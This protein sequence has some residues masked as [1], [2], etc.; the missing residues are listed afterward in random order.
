MRL[1]SV[2]WF[3]SL[4]A[5]IKDPGAFSA[6]SQLPDP[7]AQA[8]DHFWQVALAAARLD[9]DARVRAREAQLETAAAE[10]AERARA[11]A[12]REEILQQAAF[13]AAARAQQPGER[14]DRLQTDLAARDGAITRLTADLAAA[15]TRAEDF[16][17]QLASERGN[18]A[19]E[20][21]ALEARRTENERRF[22]LELDRAREAAKHA[23]ANAVTF[24]KEAA[25]RNE[26]A[27]AQI[28]AQAQDLVSLSQEA[29]RLRAGHDQQRKIAEQL[30]AEVANAQSNS[31]AREERLARQVAE[32]QAHL[33]EALAQLKAK[34]EQHGLLLQSLVATAAA[35]KAKSG[36]RHRSGGATSR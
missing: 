18:F 12:S 17:R 31:V 22:A 10:V 28:A 25:Q 8:A 13:D 29:E 19:S 30:Q 21:E 15:R 14:A 3:G 32:L 24:E 5:R 16:E 11:L 33:G 34:D 35:R 36:D 7:I 20:R 26:R 6:Q 1:S 27:Q 23:Q 4:G 9:T 2:A